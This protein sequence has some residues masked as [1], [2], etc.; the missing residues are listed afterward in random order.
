[1]PKKVINAWSAFRV[2]QNMRGNDHPMTLEEMGAF[3]SML[4]MVERVALVYDKDGNRLPQHDL[5]EQILANQQK[6]IDGEAVSNETYYL[7][8]LE[9]ENE[10]Y[11][12]S[13]AYGDNTP[14][15]TLNEEPINIR[16]WKKQINSPMTDEEKK[17]WTKSLN[18]LVAKSPVYDKEGRLLKD[19]DL[20]KLILKNNE[21]KADRKVS[22]DVFYIQ[23]P[24]NKDKFYPLTVDYGAHS[25]QM[26]KD[27]VPIDEAEM[28]NRIIDNAIPEEGSVLFDKNGKKLGTKE[29][30]HDRFLEQQQKKVAGEP[31]EDEFLYVQSATNPDKMVTLAVSYKKSGLEMSP[32]FEPISKAAVDNLLQKQDKT[33]AQEI[34]AE[35]AAKDTESAE[36]TAEEIRKEIREGIAK[37]DSAPAR[38]KEAFSG[39][40]NFK[41]TKGTER[42][43]FGIVD[44]ARLGKLLGGVQELATVLDKDGNPLEGEQWNR[45]ITEQQGKRERGEKVPK[46]T[47][48]LRCKDDISKIFAVTVKYDKHKP[49]LTLSKNPLLDDEKRELKRGWQQKAAEAQKAAVQLDAKNPK[50]EDSPEKQNQKEKSAVAVDN[51][52]KEHVAKNKKEEVAEQKAAQKVKNPSMKEMEKAAKKATKSKST[53]P[54][55]R[56]YDVNAQ[57]NDSGTWME[58]QDLSDPVPQ[59]ANPQKVVK[60]EEKPEEKQN[61]KTEVKPEANKDAEQKQKASTIEERDMSHIDQNLHVVMDTEYS[62]KEAAAIEKEAGVAEKFRNEIIEAAKENDSVRSLLANMDPAS[63]QAL[64][65]VYRDDLQSGVDPQLKGVLNKTIELANVPEKNMYGEVVEN[66]MKEID[67][68]VKINEIEEPVNNV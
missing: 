37:R 41:K 50:A 4:S 33:V 39:I 52:A 64:Y 6:K 23:N 65:I 68:Y 34:A 55:W 53:E 56:R 5:Q 42:Y 62:E 66:E 29:E 51:I 13:V 25:P 36:K 18:E 59:V 46:E 1:M 61:E 15:L 19:H 58:M 35:E 57:T 22:P 26:K 30:L 45:H 7:Q 32:G 17:E 12:V 14:E 63:M 54:S 31:V 47:F 67:E 16:D 49:T 11:E 43:G 20:E 44:V 10:V 40:K 8:S 27:L 3:N 21:E 2:V 48:Y 9:D 38:L 60:P 24:K 28:K